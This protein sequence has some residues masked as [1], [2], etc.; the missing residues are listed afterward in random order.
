MKRTFALFLAVAIFFALLL[1]VEKSAFNPNFKNPA[2]SLLETEGSL[3]FALPAGFRLADGVPAISVPR[4][5][6]ETSLVWREAWAN[7][8][9]SGSPLVFLDNYTDPAS[10]TV[11][12]G[13]VGEYLR[14]PANPYVDLG[15]LPKKYESEAVPQAW[16]PPVQ[17]RLEKIG[18]T[19]RQIRVLNA[20]AFCTPL[21]PCETG[22]QGYNVSSSLEGLYN[23]FGVHVGSEFVKKNGSAAIVVTTNLAKEPDEIFYRFLESI[24]C[25]FPQSADA[26]N[27]NASAPGMRL[28]FFS[29]KSE[30]ESF[31]QVAFSVSSTLEKPV[32][33]VVASSRN[34]T[35]ARLYR[36]DEG[37]WMRVNYEQALPT[38][39]GC[40]FG[41]CHKCT[42]QP[43]YIEDF[44]RLPAAENRTRVA[45]EITPAKPLVFQWDRLACAPSTAFDWDKCFEKGGF[46]ENKKEQ[47]PPGAYKAEFCYYELEQ[48]LLQQAPSSDLHAVREIR[49]SP[50]CIETLFVLKPPLE[51]ESRDCSA[52]ENESARQQCFLDLV[53]ELAEPELCAYAKSLAEECWAYFAVRNNQ[54]GL[55]K[56][57]NAKNE[58]G[59]N[60]CLEKANNAPQNVPCRS[61]DGQFRDSCYRELA[62]QNN[63]PKLC[64]AVADEFERGICYNNLAVI[65]KNPKLCEFVADGKTKA[66]CKESAKPAE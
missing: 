48:V 59:V 28:L 46:C 54:P 49:G 38:G 12:C 4:A 2:P 35:H 31:E 50:L 52:L 40:D 30:Y 45:V 57:T 58:F 61:R 15:L 29:G 63:L 24:E 6:G 55:C 65:T 42:E 34:P 22:K 21:K 62:L 17:Q 64:N 3:G 7:E 8:T 25:S 23:F 44:A 36:L 1:V 16:S 53:K 9:Y 26:E 41:A 13:S 47:V 33:S 43:L 14:A 19:G 51:E 5:L 20:G 37:E 27:V 60:A 11:F 18:F 66:S 56:N 39:Q 32:F 10:I